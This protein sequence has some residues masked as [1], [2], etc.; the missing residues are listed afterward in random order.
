MLGKNLVLFLDEDKNQRDLLAPR[1]SFAF[2]DGVEVKPIP[3]ERTIELMI[4]EFNKDRDR[5]R[6]LVLDEQLYETGEADYTG[7]SL[8][9]AF[10]E[11]DSVI[12]IFILT[13]HSDE[14]HLQEKYSDYDHVL[15]KEDFTTEASE[16]I[17]VHLRRQIGR[18]DQYVN[19]RSTRL[20][21]LLE[22]S[23]LGE[24]DENESNE[25]SELTVWRNEATHLSEHYDQSQLKLE[26]DEKQKT[27]DA[28]IAKMK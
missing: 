5:L 16:K 25:L 27:L 3:P 17:I 9:K 18:F 12:P 23:I 20:H 15:N 13:S 26:L 22:I 1:L 2:G 10:R 19:E 11:Y 8:A 14:G 28:I 6:A 7:S 21:Q 4:E 24:L